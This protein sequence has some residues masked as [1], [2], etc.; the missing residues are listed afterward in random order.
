MSYELCL[1]FLRTYCMMVKAHFGEF[2]DTVTPTEP[3][4]L[5]FKVQSGPSP[6]PFREKMVANY[7]SNVICVHP[8][9]DKWLWVRVKHIRV[10]LHT[11]WWKKSM[12]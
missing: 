1:C 5:L 12:K 10:A 9:G 6:P 4:N 2:A 3:H 8:H 7:C 11:T